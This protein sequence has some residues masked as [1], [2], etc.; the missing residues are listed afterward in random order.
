[1]WQNEQGYS[2]GYPYYQR[3]CSNSACLNPYCQCG[4][5][6]RCDHNHQCH[7]GGNLVYTQQKVNLSNSMRSVWEQHVYWT[8]MTIISI[9]FGLPDIDVV[10]ARL[11][12][13]AVDMGDLLKPYY[14]NEIATMYNNLIREHLVI[15]A[16]LVKAA[17]AGKQETATAAEKKWYVNGAEISQ[18]LNRINPFISREG[19][20]KMFFEHLALTKTEAVLMLQGDFKSSITVFDKIEAEALQMADTIT[21]A[22]VKQFPKMFYIYI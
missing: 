17:K 13:N 10:T 15:A 7:G 21:I 4:E 8:R 22:I 6:C 19:F 1:M 5:N 20:Q 14:G 16:E 2:G 18:F 9:A 3:N 12:R 11:L